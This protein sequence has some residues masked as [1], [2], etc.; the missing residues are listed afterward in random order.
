MILS[1]G[2]FL[3]VDFIKY[4]MQHCNDVPSCLKFTDSKKLIA[5]DLCSKKLTASFQS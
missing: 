4:G 5:L 2:V 1:D 3:L